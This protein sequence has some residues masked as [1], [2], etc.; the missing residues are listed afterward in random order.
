MR[1]LASIFSNKNNSRTQHNDLEHFT[2]NLHVH[3]L[4]HGLHQEPAALNQVENFIFPAFLLVQYEQGS[5]TLKHN[6]KILEL[7]PGSLYI[8]NPYELY[9]GHRNSSDSLIYTCIYF[10]IVPMSSRSIFRKYAY[11]G[12]DSYFQKDWFKTLGAG[13]LAD[14]YESTS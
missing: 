8:F 6:G 3:I 9:T 13:L 14:A 11:A 12:D 5:S 4:G 1:N 7:N 2:N 10:D